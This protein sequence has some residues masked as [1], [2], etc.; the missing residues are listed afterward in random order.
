[1]RAYPVKESCLAIAATAVLAL[2]AS[3][4]HAQ[5]TAPASPN[6]S[7]NPLTA[8]PAPQSGVVVETAAPPSATPARV[9]ILGGTG[10]I[11][12]ED[13]NDPRTKS[14]Q[15][16]SELLNKLK[17]SKDENRQEITKQLETKLTEY[18]DLDMKHRK[19]ELERLTKRA[20]DTEA[21]LKKREDSR[22]ELIELQL[23]SYK[24]DANGL[25]LFGEQ[26]PGSLSGRIIGWQT[27]SMMGNYVARSMRRSEKDETENPRE[28]AMSQIR[29]AQKKL[30][31]AKSDEDKTAVLKELE[32]ALGT[33][34]DRDLEE[35][36]KDLQGVR[37]ELKDFEAKLKT[38]TDSKAEIVA[39]QLKIFVNEADGLGFF[40][41]ED[42]ARPGRYGVIGGAGYGS[43]GSFSRGGFGPAIGEPV[44]ASPRK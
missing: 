27:S 42:S 10:I 44:P 7:F 28:K 34:F 26:G 32:T 13:A 35:R 16:L 40:S 20:D 43:G 23:E 41:G 3:R 21:K 9:S 33:Y 38:R 36:Q 11:Y 29:D 15:E 24:Q 31:G 2:A 8:V 1:M 19:D 30:A 37:D 6:N 5:A 17:D 4:I 22:T 39:L 14:R 12:T 18:F 25:G